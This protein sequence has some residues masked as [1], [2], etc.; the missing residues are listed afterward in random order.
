MNYNI[1]CEPIDFSDDP[2]AVLIA[3]GAYMYFL[4]KIFDLVDTV[5]IQ[6]RKKTVFC[7][8]K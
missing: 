8:K 5:R 7:S 3:T 2:D 1:L 6:Q 4:T